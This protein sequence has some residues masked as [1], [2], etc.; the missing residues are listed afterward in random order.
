MHYVDDLSCDEIA[1]LLDSSPGAVRVRLHRARRQLRAELAALAPTPKPKEEILMVEMRLEDVVVRVAEG[2]PLE[3][4]ANRRIVL[5]REVEGDRLLP[6]WV[7]PRKGT[8]SL[9]A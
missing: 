4:V 6:I 2:D 1:A 7:G 5:L 9:S 8:R 3:L